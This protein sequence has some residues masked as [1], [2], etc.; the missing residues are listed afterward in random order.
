MITSLIYWKTATNRDSS[1]MPNDTTGY[2]VEFGIIDQRFK[3]TYIDPKGALD[4]TDALDQLKIPYEVA[5]GQY[6]YHN[7]LKS[8]TLTKGQLRAMVTPE[9]ER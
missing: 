8:G 7:G 3:S 2:K 9:T 1:K 4:F 6:I 5:T